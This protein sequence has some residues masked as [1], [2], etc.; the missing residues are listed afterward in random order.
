MKVQKLTMVSAV[1]F[2]IWFLF[3]GVAIPVVLLVALV[4][5]TREVSLAIS[6]I[7]ILVAEITAVLAAI[8]V[9]VVVETLA[10]S[11]CVHDATIVEC[12]GARRRCD[13]RTAVIDGRELRAI[14][15]G[16]VAMLLLLARRVDV[17][18]VLV[19]L[20]FAGWP[21]VVAAVEADAGDVVHNDGAIERVMD[22]GNVHVVYRAVVEEL[23]AAPFASE[24]ANSG[25]TEAV[26]DAAIK[27][28]MGSP[29]ATVPD[30]DA[31]SPAPIAGRP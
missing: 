9:R 3:I 31:A 6:L 14:V 2:V 20:F 12:A 15:A 16:F 7:A 17:A 4:V 5:L 27:A 22:H 8:F 30:V 28:D 24:K 13:V 23:M 21:R 19:R 26:V 10:T 11:V 18:F 25:V 29:I 1:C